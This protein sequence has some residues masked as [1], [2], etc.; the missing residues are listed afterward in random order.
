MGDGYDT[1]VG[2]TAP[3]NVDGPVLPGWQP[4]SM[5]S[6]H[7]G[8]VNCTLGDGSVRFIKNSIDSWPY[9]PNVQWSPSLGWTPVFYISYG[10]YRIPFQVPY[11]LP[12][13]PGRRLAGAV[14]ARRRRGHRCRHLLKAEVRSLSP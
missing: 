4:L 14:D 6:L 7:P 2:T 12:G 13:R 3:P 1:L 11:I 8:G 10:R 9:D 5:M